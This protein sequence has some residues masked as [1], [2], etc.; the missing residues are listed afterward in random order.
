MSEQALF[1]AARMV[2]PDRNPNPCISLYGYG[3]EDKRCKTCDFIFCHEYRKRFWKCSQRKYSHTAKTDHR[4]KWDA[5][6]KYSE[7][8]R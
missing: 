3:P 4:L 5:C 6:G 8:N 2:A 1:D 7:V